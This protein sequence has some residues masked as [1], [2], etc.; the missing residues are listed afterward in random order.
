M[1]LQVKK[2]GG[3]LLPWVVEDDTGSVAWCGSWEDAVRTA[4]EYAR[5]VEVQLLRPD[6]LFIEHCYSWGFGIYDRDIAQFGDVE[7]SRGVAACGSSRVRLGDI[8]FA[9]VEEARRTAA[10]LLSACAWAQRPA[11]TGKVS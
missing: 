8:E 7:A 10:Q 9:S 4:N 1:T 11:V 3:S 2:T 5:A 6:K